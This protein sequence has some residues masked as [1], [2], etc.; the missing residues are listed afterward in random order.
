MLIAY[1]YLIRVP[2]LCGAAVLLLRISVRNELVAGIFDLSWMDAILVGFCA[3]I[4]TMTC[5]VTADLTLE[6]AHDRFSVSKAPDWMAARASSWLPD[7]RYPKLGK[8]WEFLV[9]TM[10]ADAAFLLM[11][12][13]PISLYL[14][15]GAMVKGAVWPG[16]TGVASYVVTYLVGWLLLRGWGTDAGILFRPWPAIKNM[17]KR[18]AQWTPAGYSGSEEQI[19]YHAGAF[20]AMLISMAVYLVIYAC[21]YF[22]VVVPPLACVLL[23][24]IFLCWVFA[25]IT[26]FADRF[27]VPILLAILLAFLY[28]GS[29]PEADH[30]FDVYPAKNELP[31]P[32]DLGSLAPKRMLVVAASGGGIHAAGWITRVIGGLYLE[33]P[34]QLRSTFVKSIRVISPVSGGS[35]GSLYLLNA[36]RDPAFRDGNY[37]EQQ[38]ED[39]I[40]LPSV[41]SSL[42]P[43]VQR[44]VF[45]DW[46]RTI[47]P[48]I[49]IQNDRG[50]AAE[51]AW[52]HAIRGDPDS[53]SHWL[54]RPMGDW[55][56]LA[57]A[58][59]VPAILFNSTIS[60][61]GERAV[62]GSSALVKVRPGRRLFR[63]LFPQRL[64]PGLVTAARLSATFPIVSPSARA[65]GIW[66]RRLRY[67]FVDGGYFDNYGVA[68]LV[69]W[70]EDVFRADP[71]RPDALLLQIRDSPEVPL[72]NWLK[73]HADAVGEAGFLNQMLTP[74]FTMARFRDTGQTAH[75]KLEGDLLSEVMGGRIHHVTFAYPYSSSPLSWHLTEADKTELWKAFQSEKLD[76]AK[77]QVCVFLA[78]GNKEIEQQCP[79]PSENTNN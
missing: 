16:V 64:D 33:L 34:K 12:Y 71:G 35:V 51:H 67:H 46:W 73:Y 10:S 5:V 59:T 57:R 53:A 32:G 54:A 21:V 42:E 8:A 78:N 75:G 18:L 31:S 44:L 19:V 26:F 14:L 66:P 50:R 58:G 11:I 56:D 28:T 68:T 3:A 60:D 47:M 27:R 69:E 25:G 49:W 20:Q 52:S 30:T 65:A 15:S 79:K 23:L 36:Y 55:A 77:Q 17:I 48:G 2:L 43:M 38:I 4:F 6:C 76:S 13:I 7:S 63:S 62:I 24:I 29:W 39:R 40:F 9:E 72:D 37:S 74:L 22:G 1:L 61:T 70:L 41:Q 45:E